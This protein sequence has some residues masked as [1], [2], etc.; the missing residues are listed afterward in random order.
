MR[1]VWIARLC[2][3]FAPW[4]IFTGYGGLVM[5]EEARKGEGASAWASRDHVR[6]FYSGHSLTEGIP[7]VVAQI[8]HSLRHRL[9]FEVQ[10]MGYSLLRQRTKGEVPSASDWPGYRAGH[11]RRGAGLN[12][13]EELRHPRR[14]T[15]GDKYDVLVVTERHDLPAIARGERTAFYLTEMAKQLVAGNPDA[16]VLFYHSWLHLNPDAP[17]PWIDYER[18]ISPMWE[19]LASRT[20]LDLPARAG[21]P[22]VRVLPGGSALA[23]MAAALWDG[24]VPGIS[25]DAPGARVRLLFSDSVHMSDAGR[26]YM[27]LVHY[28]ILFGRS[29]AGAI[30]PK[31]ISPELG[32][33]MQDLAWQFAVSYGQGANAAAQRDMA[34]CRSLMQEDVCPAYVAFQRGTRVPVVAT[35]KRQLDTY[36]CRREYADGQD[37][38]NPFAST[39][40]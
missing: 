12:V 27:A 3:V 36:L 32:R 33:F 28:A 20:N 10:V 2:A 40:E 4:I 37:P 6:A 19:C 38:A 22:R 23:E 21:G 24:K 17:W 26:Y 14:L 16:E 5:S 7:E 39:K 13:A 15:P 18:A 35:L 1:K 31:A 8:A 34:T 11:N 9:D 25:V 29:P 30:I